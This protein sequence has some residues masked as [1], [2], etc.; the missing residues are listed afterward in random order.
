MRN[1]MGDTAIR[2]AINGR[3]TLFVSVAPVSAAPA[4]YVQLSLLM[5]YRLWRRLSSID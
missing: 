1:V 4:A 3:V 2:A 5:R